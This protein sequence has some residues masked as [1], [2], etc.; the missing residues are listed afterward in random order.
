MW[1]AMGK[2]VPSVLKVFPVHPRLALPSRL[3]LGPGERQQMGRLARRPGLFLCALYVTNSAALIAFWEWSESAAG[4]AESPAP[5]DSSAP[6]PQASGSGAGGPGRTHTSLASLTPGTR[7]RSSRAVPGLCC[8]LL[9]LGW[10]PRC[11][12]GWFSV[13]ARPGRTAAAPLTACCLTAWSG[14]HGREWRAGRGLRPR[15][16][17]GRLRTP[18]IVTQSAGVF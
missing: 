7:L 11:D 3:T 16:A 5:Q 17:Q 4:L 13:T 2:S 9:A 12:C 1:A 15:A 6:H 10:W 14:P 8:P 18:P